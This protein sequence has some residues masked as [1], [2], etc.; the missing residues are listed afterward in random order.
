M[1][2]DRID[3]G[4]IQSGFNDCGRHKYIN[5]PADEVIHH[6]FQLL[7]VHLSVS[8]ADSGLRNQLAKSG[9]HLCD[10]IDTVIYI[11]NLPAAGKLPQHGLPHH[12]L[13][14]FHDIG[15]NADTVLRCLLQ[16]A[17]ITDPNHTHMKCSRNGRGGKR[18]HIHILPKLFY[19]LLVS[20]AEALL[21][22]DH[23]KPQALER[24]ILGQ[25]PVRTDHDVHPARS[26]ARQGLFLFCSCAESG[27]HLHAHRVFLHA[28]REGIEV[29]LCQNCCGNKNRDLPAVLHCLEGRPDGN[30]RLSKAHV[31]ADQ[32][33]HDLVRLHILLGI[34]NGV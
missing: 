8:K 17:H 29:L 21:L 34:C 25:E 6:L 11:V 24:H 5:L 30:F 2:D 9:R 22:I 18:Q 4:D 32:T 10:I 23:K 15:L 33:I 7:L 16:D 12:F 28:L 20:N 14:V 3:I 27:Q 26:D 13:V 31:A 19:F 1:N